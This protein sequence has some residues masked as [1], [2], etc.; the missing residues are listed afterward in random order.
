MGII[1]GNQNIENKSVLFIFMLSDWL[2]VQ[3]N[4]SA[5]YQ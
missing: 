1:V 5:V 4:K 3:K 2:A